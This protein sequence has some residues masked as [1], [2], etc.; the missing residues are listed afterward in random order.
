[1]SSVSPKRQIFEQLAIVARAL[2][3]TD[4]LDLIEQL[5]QGE[6]SVEALARRI[7]QPI[8]NTSQHLQQLR[9][10]GLVTARRDGKY[11][12]YSL[13]DV[14]VTDLVT[15]LGVVAERGNAEV[16]RV[17]R[18]Y[19]SERDGLEPVSREELMERCRRGLVTVLDV[20]P[21]EEFAAGHLPGA[22]NI[23]IDELEKRA[24]ELDTSQQVVAYCRGA[25]C[26]MSFEAVSRL[27]GRGFDARR[28]EEGLPEWKAAGFPIEQEDA[29]PA[30]GN[31][32][33]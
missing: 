21:P 26:V 9:R 11:V 29:L 30:G 23:P 28:L 7:G 1:M 5:G 2:A 3:H 15:A 32:A 18:G 27:R 14:D 16:E 31:Q 8:A 19:F 17:L 6:R 25:Y 10:A 12:R 20:R 4:R 24:A 13:A 22:V 33:Q